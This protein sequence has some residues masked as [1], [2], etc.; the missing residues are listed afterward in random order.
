[1][2][3]T[4]YPT[5]R[6]KDF[7]AYLKN[8]YTDRRKWPDDLNKWYDKLAPDQVNRGLT[9]ELLLEWMA[10]HTGMKRKDTFVSLLGNWGRWG[11][12]PGRGGDSF[13]L[14]VAIADC[15]LLIL[16][17]ERVTDP[18]LLANYLFGEEGL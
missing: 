10:E 18:V 12:N 17:G 14:M 13:P 15:G 8:F 11:T 2:A 6:K 4:V 9:V 16:D 3:I 7:G 1:M 5:D